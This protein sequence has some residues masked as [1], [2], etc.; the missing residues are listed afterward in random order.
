MFL[1]CF[2]GVLVAF[3]GVLVVF[4]VALVRRCTPQ[5]STALHVAANASCPLSPLHRRHKQ[6]QHHHSGCTPH[7]SGARPSSCRSIRVILLMSATQSA[8]SLFSMAN[9]MSST[10]SPPCH[11]Q[12]SRQPPA[13]MRFVEPTATGCWGCF[14]R[15]LC[16]VV[17]VRSAQA[18]CFVLRGATRV[19]G[20]GGAVRAPSKAVPPASLAPLHARSQ[21]RARA[22]AHQRHE[23]EAGP[24]LHR[25]RQ[26]LLDAVQRVEQLRQQHVLVVGLVVVLWGY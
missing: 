21:K 3:D 1:V 16:C 26:R 24:R 20:T 2:V 8:R 19:G 25:D 22:A 18:I 14:V 15:V 10:D 9:A 4:C 6:H 23:P 17:W 5:Q 12:P 13:A 11:A 7:R